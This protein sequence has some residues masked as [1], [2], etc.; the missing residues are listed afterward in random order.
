MTFSASRSSG[1]GGQNVN[2]IN[3]RIELRYPIKNSKILTN[4]EKQQIYKKL[5]NR[6]NSEGELIIT[7]QENRSQ[8]KNKEL[9]INKF[10]NLLTIAL[11]QQKKRVAT[12]PTKIS[13]IKR[14]EN[15]RKQSQKKK[16]R[17]RNNI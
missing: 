9:A 12:K 15:K 17:D 6:I 4:I 2:K 10:F 1:P 5:A 7:A 14:L 16:L 3:S 13:C 8:V 11:K